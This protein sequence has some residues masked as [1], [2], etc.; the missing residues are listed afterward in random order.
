MHTP[1][2][3][4][5]RSRRDDTPSTTDSSDL[6]IGTGNPSGGGH[7][8]VNAPTDMELILENYSSAV[9]LARAAHDPFYALSP[10]FR[11]AVFSEIGILDLIAAKVR[12]ELDHSGLARRY[13]F[14]VTEPTL[15]N[16]LY[17]QQMLKRHIR[18]LQ[19]PISYM[20]TACSSA[21]PTPVFPSVT[22]TRAPGIASVSRNAGSQPWPEGPAATPPRGTTILPAHSV[23]TI[24]L[25][26]ADYRAALAYAEEL[27][28]DCVQGISVVAHDATVR[29]SQKAIAEAQGVARLTRLATLL[30][31]MALVTSVFSMNVREINAGDGPPI[32]VWAVVSVVVGCLSWVFVRYD[33][34]LSWVSFVERCSWMRFKFKW[35][36]SFV[37][38]LRWTTFM[39]MNWWRRKL[40]A[41]HTRRERDVPSA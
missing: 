17:Y 40:R 18:N 21:A 28:A 27:V 3:A 41:F 4:F 39:W 6:N 34:R 35:A 20:E 16:L 23:E 33:L 32:W 22:G 8:V 11:F 13:A 15:S 24:R 14:N 38:W 30:V 29:E 7:P 12:D 31:P 36:A 1:G 25:V 26:L 10:L 19:G 5:R 37:E 9:D 2:V